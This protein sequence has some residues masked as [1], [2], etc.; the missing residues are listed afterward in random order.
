M[1]AMAAKHNNPA[2]QSEA[3]R[4]LTNGRRDAGGAGAG[5]GDGDD[6]A[7]A[8]GDDGGGDEKYT[9]GVLC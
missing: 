5:A 6:G 7:G 1:E 8:G 2:E 9:C 4:E 3:E